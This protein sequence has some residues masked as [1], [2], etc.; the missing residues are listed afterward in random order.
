MRRIVCPNCD[1]TKRPYG[2]PRSDRPKPGSPSQ[3]DYMTGTYEYKCDKCGI[4]IYIKM[5]YVLELAPVD[6]KEAWTTDGVAC[7][8]IDDPRGGGKMK[9][10]LKRVDPDEPV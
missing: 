8:I 10:Q 3:R 9:Q 5:D 2:F 4:I 6:M 1:F 7:T